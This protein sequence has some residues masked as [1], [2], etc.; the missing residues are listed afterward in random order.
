L[1]TTTHIRAMRAADTAVLRFNVAENQGLLELQKDVARQD[2]FGAETLRVRVDA[3]AVLTNYGKHAY[4]D[5]PPDSPLERAIAGNW[6][7]QTL[8]VSPVWATLVALLRA[9]DRL[10]QIWWVDN[11]NAL[12]TGARLTK[13]DLALRVQRSRK[14]GSPRL[15]T[16]RLDSVVVNP[17]GTADPVTRAP[18]EPPITHAGERPMSRRKPPSESGGRS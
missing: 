1:L 7:L 4:P 8:S 9:G 15:L 18:S 13:H 14:K 17:Y 10:E 3:P 6:V 5:D 16:V 12:L 2:G 11:R